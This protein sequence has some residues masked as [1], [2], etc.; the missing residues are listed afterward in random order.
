MGLH[1]YFLY[2]SYIF[3]TYVWIQGYSESTI[4]IFRVCSQPVRSQ[5]MNMF[6][7]RK[8]LG[9]HLD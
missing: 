9:R 6:K 3:P 5:E 7:M 8:R 2:I 1:V 4:L